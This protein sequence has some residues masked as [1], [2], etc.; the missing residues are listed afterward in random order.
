[1]QASCILCL[2][3]RSVSA[4]RLHA[5]RRTC[6]CVFL[7]SSRA[8]IVVCIS[9]LNFRGFYVRCHFS[10]T[11][12]LSAC[13]KFGSLCLFLESVHVST[14]HY[15]RLPLVVSTLYSSILN[16]EINSTR[17]SLVYIPPQSTPTQKK[18][19]NKNNN[20]NMLD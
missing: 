9:V 5:C 6:V 7:S 4:L 18:N 8:V 15:S 20:F 11:G 14:E 12:F 17:M 16:L 2:S 13:P 3:V 1:M 19:A 10:S